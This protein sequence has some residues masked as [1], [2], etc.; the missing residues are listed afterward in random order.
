MQIYSYTH[1]ER[2][3]M[4]SGRHRLELEATLTLGRWGEEK[5]QRDAEL[6]EAPRSEGTWRPDYSTQPTGC[7]RFCLHTPTIPRVNQG[8]AGLKYRGYRFSSIRPLA[9]RM[10]LNVYRWSF[11]VAL[12]GTWMQAE[13]GG[14]PVLSGR[15]VLL[16]SLNLLDISPWEICGAYSCGKRRFMVMGLHSWKD[17]RL[18]NRNMGNLRRPEHKRRKHI[19]VRPVTRTVEDKEEFIPGLAI[20]PF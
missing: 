4:R 7:T 3:Q 5:E 11:C 2:Q 12:T 1:I 19:P 20:N 10:E 17:R 16:S 15:R 9:G 13:A 6:Q 8:G 14:G 18:H